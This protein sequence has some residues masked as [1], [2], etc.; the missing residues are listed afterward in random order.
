MRL[1]ICGTK[2]RL[3][4]NIKILVLTAFYPI[5]DVTRERMFVHV[6]DR[7]Y[8]DH[9]EDVTVLNFAAQQDYEIDGI[10]VITPDTYE[11]SG[12]SYDI[13]L[14]HSANVRNHYFFLR[15]HQQDFDRIVFF[16]HGHEVLYLNRDYPR[17]YPYVSGA[18]PVKRLIQ[19]VYDFCKL[20]IWRRYYRKLAPKSDFVFVSRWLL[21][22]AL[23]NLRLDEEALLYHCHIIP[24]SIG[25]FFEQNSY[26]RNAEKSYDLITIRSNLDGSTYCADLVTELAERYGNYRFLLI[27]KGKFF[28]HHA[29]PANLTWIDRGLDHEEMRAYLDSSRCALMLT[30]QDTHGVMACE[31]VSYGL[32]LISSDIAVCR[33]VFE[34][35]ENVI[36][37][38]NDT[39]RIDLD[40][41]MSS[42]RKDGAWEKPEKFFASETTEKELALLRSLERQTVRAGI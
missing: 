29:L 3:G 39:E 30:R 37:V 21:E 13:A 40:S 5:P 12:E 2:E 6:R 27:G 9:G 10:R 1:K 16:F 18:K 34:G 25:S 38:P 20:H 22:R 33:E 32:P 14:C 11:T 35:M 28:L 4:I 41:I 17:P 19:G 42:V 36:L 23:K 31:L 8:A 7:Y 26:D 24:N 15:K